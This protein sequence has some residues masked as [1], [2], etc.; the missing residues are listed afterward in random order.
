MLIA[1]ACI[2]TMAPW[3]FR[4]GEWAEIVGVRMVL[5]EDGCPGYRPCFVVRFKDGVE[6]HWVIHDEDAHYEFAPYNLETVLGG[7]SCLS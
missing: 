4:S 3:V 2:R 5:P 1:L 7:K 6:D